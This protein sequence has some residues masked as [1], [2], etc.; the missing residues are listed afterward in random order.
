MIKSRLSRLGQKNNPFCHSRV[1]VPIPARKS[2]ALALSVYEYCTT[3]VVITRMLRT[4]DGKRIK[5]L[6][7]ELT[8]T[9]GLGWAIRLDPKER[10]A[11]VSFQDIRGTN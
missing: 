9:A 1:S 3:A 7:A 4:C 6:M 2:L 11:V 5:H 8:G 10:L